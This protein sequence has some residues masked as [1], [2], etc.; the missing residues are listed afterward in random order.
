MATRQYVGARYVPKFADPIEWDDARAYEA[1]EIV[2]YQNTS[3]TSKKPV[4]VGTA[5]TNSEYWVATGNYN[6]QV[7][8]Y[9]Q[10]VE[11]Y[12][13][14][15]EG[16]SEGFKSIAAY[17]AVGD[18][19]TDDTEA[20]SACVADCVEE[21]YGLLIPAD[22]NIKVSNYAEVAEVRKIRC[23]GEITAP[24]G[25]EFTVDAREN[26]VDWYIYSVTGKLIMSGM[27]RGF[28][29]VVHADE[30]ELWADSDVPTK[31]GIGYITFD[32]GDIPIFTMKGYH[33]GWRLCIPKPHR[34]DKCN[35]SR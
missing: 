12:K 15:V 25:I 17:G 19:V 23:Y 10:E 4:P 6:A 34:V 35:Y 18:G 14:E 9:R 30:L 16:L 7:E 8:A 21:G 31:Y 24:N 11:Q 20:L 27:K 33:N 28:V 22:M 32:F 3:Y 1:L 26:G 29:S 5:I 13:D 2:T